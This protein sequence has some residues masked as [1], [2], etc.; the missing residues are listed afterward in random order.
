[1]VKVNKH[2]RAKK[3]G[4]VL[5]CPRCKEKNKVYHFSFGA[6]TCEGCRKMINKY[7]WLML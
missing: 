3:N 1:M 5:V 4:T 2:T 7:D 6:F